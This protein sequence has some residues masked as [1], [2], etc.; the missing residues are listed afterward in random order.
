M[1][2]VDR[3]REHALGPNTLSAAHDELLARGESVVD[4]VSGNLNAQGLRFP[5]EALRQALEEARPR[6]ATYTPDPLGRIEAREA[7]AAY[8]EPAGLRVAPDR[9][10]VTP[11]TSVSYLYAFSVLCEPGDEV[12]VPRPSYPLFDE[13]ARIPGV[14]LAPYRLREADGWR[15]DLEHLESQVSTRTRAIVLISPH[16]PTG[17]V[18]SAAEI[19]GLAEIARRHDLAILADEVFCEFVFDDGPFARPA[20]AG[21]APRPGTA[22]ARAAEA[23]APFVLTLNGFSKMFSLPGWKVGW[24]L[25]TGDEDRAAKAAWMLSHVSDAFLVV[26]ELAQC[27]VPGIFAGAAAFPREL[28]E[29][30]R[31]GRDVALATLS[32]PGVTSVVPP[33]GGLFLTVRLVG[34]GLEEEEIALDLLRRAQVLVHPGYYY[35]LPP[36]HLVLSY[37]A[38]E[39]TLRPALEKIAARLGTPG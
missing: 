32:L 24:I 12:L 17:A 9:I 39:E 16:N 36:D 11:G 37:A 2:R 28:R 15:I 23:G 6:A 26:N 34:A 10:V 8:Y 25:V 29:H 27:A 14:R 3:L 22:P 31:R 38:R 33:K 21:A 7:I 20:L 19:E 13:I 4:L 35:D 30:A 1:F 5:E 18:A